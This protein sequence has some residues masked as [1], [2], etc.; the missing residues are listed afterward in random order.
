[1]IR[2]RTALPCASQK[3]P[4]EDVMAKGNNAR[5]KETKKPKKDKK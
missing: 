3:K 4:E 5:K 2:S 1:M